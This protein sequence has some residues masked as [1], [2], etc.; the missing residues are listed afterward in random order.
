MEGE[1]EGAGERTNQGT[2]ISCSAGNLLFFR[3]CRHSGVMGGVMDF[4]RAFERT[5][6]MQRVT[7]GKAKCRLAN[8]GVTG[9]TDYSTK[10]C[11]P[12]RIGYVTCTDA[13]FLGQ[14]CR[15]TGP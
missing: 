14:E 5:S 11:R 2:N 6:M 1:V 8:A 13:G 3:T 12:E 10:N 4:D 15:F 7:W 9:M